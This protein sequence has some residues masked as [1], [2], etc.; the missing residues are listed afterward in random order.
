MIVTVCHYEE[1]VYVEMSFKCSVCRKEIFETKF[2]L[3]LN[4]MTF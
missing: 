2:S 1:T 3:Q 4:E